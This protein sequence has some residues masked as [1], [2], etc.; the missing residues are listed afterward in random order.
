MPIFKKNNEKIIYVFI[1]I[2]KTGG[3]S[4][5]DYFFRKKHIKRNSDSLF[6]FIPQF[7]EPLQHLQYS[8]IVNNY[9]KIIDIPGTIVK[10][11]SV[12]RNPYDRII[13]ELFYIK[14]IN[15]N[16]S[17]KEIYN[18]IKEFLESD[19]TYDN[20]KLQQYYFLVDES[21]GEIPNHITIFST[22][23][24][25]EELKQ[26]GF[27]DFNIFKNKNV[28]KTDYFNLH[29]KETIEL[30]NNYYDIDFKTF[31]YEKLDPNDFM[32]IL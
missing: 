16:S 31:G 22:E 17:K 11:F 7:K 25:T 12:V 23:T 20:H 2:P 6:G 8:K 30:I 28:N 15:K 13:S 27:K 1:H 32:S 10:Y 29:S 9:K 5:E 4:I 19:N 24:L 26:Y 14:M 18:S 3:T 21:S